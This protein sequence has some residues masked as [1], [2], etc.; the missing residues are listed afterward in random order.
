MSAE[1]SAECRS[2]LG[3]LSN[4]QYRQGPGASAGLGGLTLPVSIA[5]VPEPQT[6]AMLPGGPVLAGGRAPPA[7]TCASD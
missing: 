1:V 3:E 2:Y 6:W 5:P 4:E 7:A